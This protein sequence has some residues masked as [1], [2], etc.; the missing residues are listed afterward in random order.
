MWLSQPGC[1]AS[2]SPRSDLDV[3]LTE[4][5]LCFCCFFSPKHIELIVIKLFHDKRILILECN[6][7]AESPVL[8]LW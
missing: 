2:M 7:S 1:R 6:D 4:V 3:F 8:I 5:L